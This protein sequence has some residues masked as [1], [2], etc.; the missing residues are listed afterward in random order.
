[1]TIPKLSLNRTSV[2]L[3]L[4][5]GPLAFLARWGPQSNQRGIETAHPRILKR[6]GLPAL[7][8]TSVGLKH[9]YAWDGNPTWTPSIEPAWD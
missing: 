8:R 1:M 6:K 9:E 4:G 7:N 2:G 3:K 5:F